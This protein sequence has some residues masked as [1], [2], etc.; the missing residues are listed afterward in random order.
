MACEREEARGGKDSSAYAKRGKSE[1]SADIEN[2][3]GF[4]SMVKLN[5][6]C[7]ALAMML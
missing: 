4:L 2:C 1:W 3:K 5:V 7:V 6:D